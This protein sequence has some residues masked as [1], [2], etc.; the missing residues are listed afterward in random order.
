MIMRF[1]IVFIMIILQ[2]LYHSEFDKLQLSI[3]IVT[4]WTIVIYTS[5]V[6]HA[7]STYLTV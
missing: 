5:L 3:I 7:T 6:I 1:F 2:L 4:A